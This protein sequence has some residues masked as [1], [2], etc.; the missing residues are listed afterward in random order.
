MAKYGRY[1]WTPEQMERINE[2]RAA[3]GQEELV[4]LKYEDKPRMERQ[5]LST[6]PRLV[7]EDEGENLSMKQEA[8]ERTKKFRE[9]FGAKGSMGIERGVKSGFPS[10]VKKG[11]KGGVGN[12]LQDSFNRLF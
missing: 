9:R 7:Q 3:R 6:K 1:G 11:V 2:R 12:S 4:N 8:E 5:R 10:A